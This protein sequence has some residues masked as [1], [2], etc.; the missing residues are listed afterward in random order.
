MGVQVDGQAHLLLQGGHQLLGGVGL[1]QAGHVLDGQ[2]VGA[3]LLQLLGKIHV[4]FQGVLVSG[5][6]QNVAGVAHGGLQQLVL[7]E[8]FL[9]GHLHARHPVQG[10]EH[11]EHVDAPLGGLL[12][13]GA[14]KVIGIVGV[15]HQIGAPQQHLEG[16]VGDLFPQQPQTLPGGLMQEAVGH[17]ERGTAPHL[18][19]E[20]V[21]ED[22]GHAVG[23]L[24]HVAGTH[25]GGQQALVGVAHGG[26]G[27]Q[28][29]LLIQHPL[30]DGLGALLIQ[31]LLQA[32]AKRLPGFR[33]A[34]DIVLVALGVGVGHLNFG[35]ISQH[36]GSAVTRIHDLEQLRRLVDELGVALAAD[37]GGVGQHI[38]DKGDVGLDAADAHLVDGTGCLA[39]DGGEA[40]IPA[41]D[42]HQQRVVIGGDDGAHAHVAAVQ[43]DAEAARG[44]VSGDLAVIGGEVVG[45]ILG[46]D[47]ALDGVA[48]EMHVLL[49]GQADLRAAEGI[50][51]RH[52]QLGADDIHAG[53]HFGDGVLH[54]NTGVHLDEVVM[55]GLV[56]QK[57]HRT[58]A[59]VV[60]GLGDLHRVLT[61]SLHRLLGDRPRGRVLH[62]LLIP[63]LEGAVTLA[64]MVHVAVLVGQ[65]LHL[66]V[67]G[68]HKEL[69]NKDIA[70]AEGLL[71]FAVH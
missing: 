43:T 55:A 2:H 24:H 32:G 27:Q 20:A 52:Q 48:V 57:L 23:A 1:Q 62:H 59:D 38:G 8:D 9:H 70:A 30:L 46:G 3:P 14:D 54:L 10:V 22:I 65:D 19:R 11:A 44:V 33:E 49:T 69:L 64:Q 13:E 51:R 29:L 67:L 71:R 5:L 4:V 56:H 18:Q 60:D 17:I 50:A 66:D 63:A 58:G 42:L 6:V 7:A 31:Q 35:D 12:H 41:G 53:D 47:A 39:A 61:Q 45:G 26:V 25:T 16:N 37:E 34:G 15:A 40:A 21:A 28:Q 68:L 36:T